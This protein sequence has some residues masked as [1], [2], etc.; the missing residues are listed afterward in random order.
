MGLAGAAFAPNVYDTLGK[1]PPR[2]RFER[3]GEL[4]VA[5][6]DEVREG[7]GRSVG[8]IEKELLQGKG[9]ATRDKGAKKA[10]F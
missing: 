6:V 2:G 9:R 1:A 10:K 4:G 5:A 7:R 3:V 8:E